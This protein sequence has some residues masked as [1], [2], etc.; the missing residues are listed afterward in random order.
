MQTRQKFWLILRVTLATILLCVAFIRPA[1]SQSGPDD[2]YLPLVSKPYLPLPPVNNGDFELGRNGDWIEYSSNNLYY[3]IGEAE[4][5]STTPSA[6]S[7]TWIA[8]LGGISDEVAILSQ[9]VTLPSDTPIYL[10]Y[11][12]QV[13]SDK[14][15]C[16]ADWM[17]L[18]AGAT[19]LESRGLCI[20]AGTEDWIADSVNLS[21]Y[22]GQTI[23][24]AFE[25]TTNSSSTYLSSFFIDDVSL[26]RNP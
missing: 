5:P 16:N 10:H 19:E 13:W 17:R 9:A 18:Y 7:G 2:L 3:L 23:T 11:D 20:S 8:W 15:A 26:S 1:A 25:V 12:Y 21:A 14:S 22:A 24:I 6:H 4:P